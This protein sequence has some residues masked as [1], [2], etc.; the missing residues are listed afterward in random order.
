MHAAINQNIHR[1]ESWEKV[2]GQALYT[3]DLPVSGL[4]CARLLVSPH[5]HALVNRIDT[6][7]AANLPGVKAIV[8]GQNCPVL[9]GALLRDRPVLALDRVRYAGEPVA[10]V[11]ALDEA[12][13][14]AAVELIHVDYSPLP[15][16]LRPSEAL[17]PS[18]VLLHGQLGGYQRMMPDITPQPG[19]NIAGSYRIRKGDLGS[20]WENCIHTVE[21]RFFLP[22]SDHA[23]MEV[24]TARAQIA[25][26]GAVCITTASQAPF[27][28]KKQLAEYFDI[29]AG[30]IQVHVPFVGGA[31]GG[32]APVMLE[33]LAYLASRQVGGRA[34]RL[35]IPREQDMQ[36]APC[37]LGLEALIRLGADAQGRLMAAQLTYWLDCGAYTDIAPYMTKAMA[38]DCTGPYRVDNL[39][40]DAYCVYTNHTYATSYRSFGHE[41]FTFCIERSLDLLCGKMGMDPLQFR[42][43]NALR[44]GDLTPTR[45]G[46]TASN[47]GDLPACIRA[48]GRLAD[49]D[50][51]APRRLENGKVIAKGVSCLWKAANPPTDAISGAMITFNSDGSVNLNTGVVEMGSASQTHLAQMLAEKLKMH[52]SRVHAIMPVD[53]RLNPEHWKTVASLTGYMAGHAV[54]KAAEDVLDQLKKIGALA[55]GCG[56]ADVDVADCRVYMRSRPQRFIAFKD[57]VQGYQAQDGT[58]IGWPVMG[59]GG[60]MLKGLSLLDPKTGEGKTGPSWTVGAQCVEVEFDPIDFSYRILTAST[61][62]DVGAP[63]NPQGERG[64]IA[65]GMAMGISMASRE[66]FFYT[67]DGQLET[68]TLRTYKLMH[69]GQEPDYRVGMIH[70]PQQDAPYGGR[71]MSEHGIIGIPAA[72][73]NALSLAAGTAFNQLPL[74]PESLWRQSTGGPKT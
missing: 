16:V 15:V 48:L 45:V 69:I 24:R 64:M 18:A 58:S 53:T 32:K 43:I 46:C 30:K 38:A 61:V 54:L 8:T 56:A 62:M 25:A 3:D 31:F 10:M 63:I 49:Y 68:P 70:T 17:A 5:A 41:S 21:Q 7:T 11:I 28:V 2:T 37:R 39:A 40:C 47:T 27:T 4:L 52:P 42:L 71:S 9:C 13:A 66:G 26:D 14:Q 57:I 6:R 22:P 1:K 36:S 44:P 55:F 59:R 74:T 29:P 73:A 19:T 50:D 34:V 60:F 72:L 23:A 67:P 51:A 65:G 33:I 20:G 12:T 35:V